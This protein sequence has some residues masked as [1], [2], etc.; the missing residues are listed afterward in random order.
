MSNQTLPQSGGSYVR[1]GDTLTPADDA[2]EAGAKPAKPNTKSKDTP[3]SGK[4]S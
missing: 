2:K 4:D 1:D 3:K